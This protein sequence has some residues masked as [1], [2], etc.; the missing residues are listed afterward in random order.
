MKSHIKLKHCPFTKEEDEIILQHVK[1]TKSPH[2]AD[3]AS[4]LQRRSVRQC[5]KRYKELK[6]KAITSRPWNSD[7]DNLLLQKVKEN[8]RKW[9]KIS[10]FFVERTPDD[11]K[12]RYNVII[13]HNDKISSLTKQKDSNNYESLEQLETIV[14]YFNFNSDISD[15]HSRISLQNN[16]PLDQNSSDK[17]TN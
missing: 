2:W 3:V 11:L 7:E 14:N 8:G 6:A 15:T 16:P 5:R 4:Q 10:S 9:K 17:N 13:L 1:E 12:N